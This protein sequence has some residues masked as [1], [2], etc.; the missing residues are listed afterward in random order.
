M[1]PELK[2][3]IYWA[4]EDFP[5]SGKITA[6]NGKM[7]S[8]KYQYEDTRALKFVKKYFPYIYELDIKYM[9]YA[10]KTA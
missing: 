10:K 7:K 4:D 5:S 3:I 1:F 6:Q 9:E 8:E 2:F